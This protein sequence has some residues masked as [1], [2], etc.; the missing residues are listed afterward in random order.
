MLADQ[1]R[2]RPR[3]VGVHVGGHVVVGGLRR[4]ADDRLQVFRQRLELRLA[5]DDLGGKA[6][7]DEAREIVVLGDLVKAEREVV[8]GADELGRVERTRLQRREDFARRH[9]RHRGAELAP[10]LAAEAG[11]AEAQ[12]LHVGDAGQLVR[13]QPPA[14]VPVS[15]DRKPWTPNWS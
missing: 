2:K 7:F 1:R 13:N 9:V 14:C 11:R 12:A 15:P 5:D 4:R 8:V 3:V 10:H 6:R